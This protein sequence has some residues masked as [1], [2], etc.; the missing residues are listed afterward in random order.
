MIAVTASPTSRAPARTHLWPGL[1]RTVLRYCLVVAA[2]LVLLVVLVAGCG[3]AELPPAA[4][5]TIAPTTPAPPP[6][7]TTTP[8]PTTAAPT[9]TAAPE[10]AD[11]TNGR[12]APAPHP[13]APRPGGTGGATP[14][15]P[16][17]DAAAA[18]GLQRSVD[19][20]RQPWLLDPVQVAVSYAGAEL[21]YRDPGVFPISAGRVDLQD[22]RS[23]AKATVTLAQTVRRGEG[24]IWLVTGV[25]RR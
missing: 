2:G 3:V 23:A 6:V 9:T 12:A 18:A 21:G 11:R 7:P 13:D 1:P 15:W 4:P 24:G 14:I 22:G 16:A 25:A 8:A 19:G 10:S 20:G 5:T 17:S